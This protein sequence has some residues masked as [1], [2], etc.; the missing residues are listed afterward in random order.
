MCLSPV[1]GII[2]SDTQRLVKMSFQEQQL[3]VTLGKFFSFTCTDVADWSPASRC[4]S[5]L[6]LMC[7]GFLII[8][9]LFYISCCIFSTVAAVKMIQNIFTHPHQKIWSPWQYLHICKSICELMQCELHTCKKKFSQIIFSSTKKLTPP[10]ESVATSLKQSFFYFAHKWQVLCVLTFTPHPVSQCKL[11]LCIYRARG[12]HSS[13]NPF[14][15]KEPVWAPVCVYCFSKPDEMK[16][17][18]HFHTYYKSLNCTWLL[19]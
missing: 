6:L 4:L 7:A 10:L 17:H 15:S 16:P 18:S 1:N 2:N 8:Y 12:R 19:Q 5:C 9:A 11:H 13:E 3:T 14:E